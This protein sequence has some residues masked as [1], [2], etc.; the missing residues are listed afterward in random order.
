MLILSMVM[1]VL[2][3]IKTTPAP[4]LASP[5][6]MRERNSR[7]LLGHLVAVI[8]ENMYPRMYWLD[9]NI[10]ALFSSSGIS[11][12]CN[13]EVIDVIDITNVTNL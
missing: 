7:I 6:M 12:I 2:L 1:M 13:D 5:M 4:M 8:A 10:E 9:I 11:A 3:D